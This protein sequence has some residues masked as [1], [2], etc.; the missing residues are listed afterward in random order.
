MPLAENMT[1]REELEEFAE[2]LREADEQAKTWEE[3]KQ[4][5][6]GPFLELIT[7]VVRDEMELA[8]EVVEVEVDPTKH[9]DAEEWARFNRPL[10]KVIT[11]E[12]RSAK[13]KSKGAADTYVITLE[14]NEAL[15][16]FEFEFDGYKFGRTVKMTGKGFEAQRFHQDLRGKDIDGIDTDLRNLMADTVKVEM[17]PQYSFNEAEAIKIMAEYPETVEI[18]QRYINPGTPSVA[19]LPIKAVKETEE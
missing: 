5:A 13:K 4:E 3:A 18:F 9:F 1:A 15:T 6:R 17:V 11:V 10:M 2:L 14:D 8:R 16:K 12:P 19:L 7:E